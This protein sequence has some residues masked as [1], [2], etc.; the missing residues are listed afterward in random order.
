MKLSAGRLSGCTRPEWPGFGDVSMPALPVGN[1][2]EVR[3][4]QLVG[5]RLAR[6]GISHPAF[7]QVYRESLPDRFVYQA[8]E[9]V[10]RFQPQFETRRSEANQG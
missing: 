5:F 10:N 9:I 6:V 4:S 8:F 3:A 2:I 1:Q 7:R